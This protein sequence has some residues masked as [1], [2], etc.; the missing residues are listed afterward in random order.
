MTS[1][2]Q[3]TLLKFSSKIKILFHFYV[4]V[5]TLTEKNKTERRHFQKM[6]VLACMCHMIAAVIEDAFRSLHVIGSFWG[7]YANISSYQM[8]EIFTAR[9][10][11]FDRIQR[12]GRSPG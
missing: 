5:E 3:V 2:L 9:N 4:K 1:D 10:V 6:G 11:F 7:V 8:N 12:T